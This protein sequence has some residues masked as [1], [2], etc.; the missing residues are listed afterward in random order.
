MEPY[1]IAHDIEVFYVKADS[2][3]EGIKPAF[4][5]LIALLPDMKGR[6]LYGI[7]RPED[8][9]GIVYRAAVVAEATGEGAIYGLDSFTIRQGVYMSEI[10]KDYEEHVQEVSTTFDRLLQTPGL[11]P[12]GYCV[13]DYL[14][15]KDVRCM[16]PLAASH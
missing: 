2:F 3:P 13:E 14:N 15:E 11:D 16:V 4:E 12:Q 6:K 8:G 9:N 10:L 7:S 1:T 5:K